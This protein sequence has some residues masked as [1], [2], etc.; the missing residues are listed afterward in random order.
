MKKTR[1]ILILGIGNLLM[2]D[3]GVGVHIAQELMKMHLPRDVEVIDGGTASLDLISYLEGRKKVVVIDCVR[4]GH[5]PGTIYRLTPEEVKEDKSKI[6]S[7]HQIDFQQ[8]LHLASEFGK[9]PETVIIGIE[10]K[11]F[12]SWGMELSAVVKRRIPRVVEL[13]KEEAKIKPNG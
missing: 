11:N 5:K 1:P 8:T 9:Q 4:G 10:P 12:S 13:V 6:L 3:E 2:K 7:L